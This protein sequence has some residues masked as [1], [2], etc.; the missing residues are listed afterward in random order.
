M[1]GSHGSCGGSRRRFLKTAAAAGRRAGLGRPLLAAAAPAESPCRTVTLGKTGQKVTSS[2]WGRAGPS[3]PSFVQAALCRGRPLHRHLGVVRERPTPRRSSARSSNGPRCARTSTSSPRTPSYAAPG[4]RGAEVF[5]KH[6]ER[7]PRAAPDRLRRLLLPPRHHGQRRSR[8]LRDP[9]VKAAFEKLKKAGQD[10]LLRPELPR[11]RCF[12]RSSRPPPSRLDRPGDV[13]VQLP[14]RRRT[15]RYDDLQ[16]AIDKASKA[17]LGLV[18][19]KTQ[20]GA[21]QLPRR[22]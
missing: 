15:D 11:R 10:P 9:G 4:R 16:R 3:Q 18:A 21:G 12:P 20:G 19:M 22:R 13:Q 17:N 1:E 6:L 14:R 7:Q 2:A 8:M 5:E